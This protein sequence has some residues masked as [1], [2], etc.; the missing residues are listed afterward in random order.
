M[1][2]QTILEQEAKIMSFKNELQKTQAGCK[3]PDVPATGHGVH[4]STGSG[5]SY[6]WALAGLVQPAGLT[7]TPNP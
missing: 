1:P 3:A 6:W 4:R 2:E 7:T 5:V